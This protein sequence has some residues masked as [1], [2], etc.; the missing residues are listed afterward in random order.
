MT[1][2]FPSQAPEGTVCFP[3]PPRVVRKPAIGGHL[4]TQLVPSPLC[5]SGVRVQHFRYYNSHAFSFFWK[6]WMT[7]FGHWGCN[8][9][10]CSQ[11]HLFPFSLICLPSS[12]QG[13]SASLKESVVCVESW[14]R[15]CY[16]DITHV[17]ECSFILVKI[18]SYID[19]LGSK[20]AGGRRRVPVL[21]GYVLYIWY[22]HAIPTQ[23]VGIWLTAVCSA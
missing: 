8:A 12:S 15:H 9:G 1:W 4:V 18:R 16:L 6:L 3:P 21:A 14:E 17:H 11:V 7:V 5:L 13:P 22:C 23:A 2:L 19:Y 20:D 10:C